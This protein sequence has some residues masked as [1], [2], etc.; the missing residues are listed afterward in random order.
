MKKAILLAMLMVSTITFAQLQV[1]LGYNMGD[2]YG[3]AYIEAGSRKIGATFTFG[4]DSKITYGGY[5]EGKGWFGGSIFYNI[6][7]E[8]SDHQLKFRLGGEFEASY[9]AHDDRI[10]N[11]SSPNE[12]RPEY[13]DSSFY[14]MAGVSYAWKG[15]QFN[16]NYANGIEYGI[17]VILKR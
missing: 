3:K 13:V 9:I 1:G 8:N 16:L 14:P 7:D 10:D 2:E 15:I 5:D 4:G 11:F 6:L 12:G 17:G